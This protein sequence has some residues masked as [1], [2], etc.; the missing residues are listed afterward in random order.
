ML[1]VFPLVKWFQKS[2]FTYMVKNPATPTVFLVTY[3]VIW[4]VVLVT[5]KITFTSERYHC[6]VILD[7][8]PT[9]LKKRCGLKNDIT[10]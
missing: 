2:P 10:P 8:G 3:S 6:N 9:L 4:R 1:K 7:I 5:I